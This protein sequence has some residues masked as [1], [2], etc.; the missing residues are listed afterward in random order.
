MAT[1]FNTQDMQEFGTLINRVIEHRHSRS[2]AILAEAFLSAVRGATC[3]L[4]HRHELDTEGRKQYQ[5]IIEYWDSG[6]WNEDAL[7]KVSYWLI[8]EQGFQLTQFKT[9]NY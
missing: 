4:S 6:E 7:I 8:D 9:D 3:C 5:H 2:T 1:Q